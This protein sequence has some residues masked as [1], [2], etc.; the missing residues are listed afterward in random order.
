[1]PTSPSVRPLD[2]SD[3]EIRGALA[4]AHLPSLLASLAQITGDRTLL[5]DSLRPPAGRSREASGGLEEAAQAEAEEAAFDALVRYRD[6]GCRA[7][8]VPD[9]SELRRIMEF[10]IGEPTTDEYLSFLEA[11]LAIAE[12][13]DEPHWQLNDVAPGRD[14]VVAIVGAGM[15]GLA[16]AH[17]L[18]QAGVPFVVFEKNHDVGGTWLENTYPGCQVDVPNHVY[19]YSFA[20]RHDWPQRYS[21]QPVLLDYFRECADQFGLR[22]HIR[23]DTEVRGAEFDEARGSWHLRFRAADG[24]EESFAAD[25]LISGVGQLNRPKFPDISGIDRF[26][27]PAFHTAQWDHDVDLRG[28][29]VAVIGT[30]ASGFQCIPAIAGD[31]TELIVF[32][33][34]PNWFIPVPDYHDALPAGLRWLFERVPYY[35]QWYRFVLFFWAAE[36]LHAAARVEPDRTTQGGPSGVTNDQLRVWFTAYLEQQFADAPELLARVV[37]TYPPL[38][39]RPLLDDGTVGAHAATRQRDAGDRQDHRDHRTGRRHQ[40][41]PRACRRRDRVRHGLPSIAFPHA[42]ASAGPRWHRSARALGRTPG[43]PRHHRARVSQPLFCLYGPNTNIVANGS[44]IFFSEAEVHYITGCIRLLL[45]RGQRAMDCRPAVHDAFNRRVDEGNRAMVWGAS[46][47][48]SWYKNEKG[49][50]TQCWPFS[51]LEFWQLT[52]E[53]NPDDFELL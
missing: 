46:E 42:H 3:E 18:Q 36:G 47:V 12:D 8:P 45:E 21:P 24:R 43:A 23:F 17:R 26:A 7:E 5:R 6:G 15:S 34:T 10:A 30:G 38:A 40:R 37:P 16:A 32:Q 35:C 9:P 51:L 52:R 11:E 1:M 28:K 48:N 50:V 31:V 13:A 14:F 20:Q 39:K 49:R 22:D 53:P 33:R 2:A 19:S 44:I 41:R 29:R 27:G 25:A 4:D